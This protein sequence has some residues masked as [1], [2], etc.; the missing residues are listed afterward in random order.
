MFDSNWRIR[1]SVISLSL[2]KKL[3]I[4]PQQSSITFVG[5]LLFKVSVYQA[6]LPIWMEMSH[7]LKF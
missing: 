7:W 4:C 2:L 6:N 5:E 1:V 3:N